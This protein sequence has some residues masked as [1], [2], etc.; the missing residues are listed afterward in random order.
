MLSITINTG[1]LR[2]KWGRMLNRDKIAADSAKSSGAVHTEAVANGASAQEA[3]I[4]RLKAR[5]AELERL[6]GTDTLTPL[7]NRRHFMQLLDRWCW[8]AQRYGGQAGLLYL[9]VDNLKDVNDSHGHAAGDA[10][11]VT[12]ADGLLAMVRKSD[13]VARI[14]GDEFVILLESIQPEKLPEKVAAV[15]RH[16]SGLQVQHGDL[17]LQPSVAVG[18]VPIRSGDRPEALLRAADK[19]MY[20]DK[21]ASEQRV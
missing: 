7:F 3:E 1:R 9:D 18:C 16:I 21:K 4:V 6:V 12:I 15:K 2:D 10:L 13:I 11:L 19:A 20:A 8:R 5:I 14:G 17:K